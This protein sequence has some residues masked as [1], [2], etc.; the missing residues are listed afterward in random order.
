M[1]VAV[2]GATGRTGGEVAREAA[3]RGHEVVSLSRTPEGDQH[4][5]ADLPAVLAE[6]D[7]L[8]DFTVPEATVEHAAAAADAGVPLVVGTTGFDE[9]G[10]AA[11]RT[12]AEQTPVLKASNFAKGV[13]ALRRVVRA[14]VAALPDYDVEV[15]ETHHSG[16]RDAPSGTA[17]TLLE[18]IEETRSDALERTYGREGTHERA[19][20][21]IG[22]HVRRAGTV[23]GEHE[24]LLAGDDEVLTLT[25]RAESRRVFAAGAVDA[26]EQL[27][28][29]DPGFYDFSE[30]L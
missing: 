10:L 7:A 20:E 24:V 14:G 2:A 16:K 27:A 22:V 17:L 1:R 15:T 29:R 6:A 9:D 4:D 3:K 11:L 21:E 23:R 30:V 18:D 13:Q 8:V 25:H 28:G 5:I 26:A 12:A 19:P